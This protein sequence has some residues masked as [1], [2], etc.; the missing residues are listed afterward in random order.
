MSCSLIWATDVR[1]QSSTTSLA[2][3]WK[4]FHSSA[5]RARG[6]SDR[7]VCTHHDHIVREDCGGLSIV[8]QA[9]A[10]VQPIMQVITG[11]AIVLTVYIMMPVGLD[12]YHNAED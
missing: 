7:P 11:L 2:M 8:R 1:A 9:I 12:I 3:C 5:G 6:S 4:P 10:P